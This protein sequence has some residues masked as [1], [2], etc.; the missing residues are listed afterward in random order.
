MRILLLEDDTTIGS[1]VQKGLSEEGH[2]VDLFTNGKDALVAAMTH[3]FDLFIFDRMVPE[4]DGLSLLKSLRASKNFTPVLFLTALGELDDRV[5]GFDAGGDDYL[6]KPFAFAELTAR[7]AALGRRGQHS[8]PNEKPSVL[9]GADIKL[10]LLARTCVRRGQ[11]IPLNA[12]EFRLLEYFMRRP[13]RVV[14]RTMLLEAVWEMS[15]DPT[16]SVVETHISR[17]RSKIEKPFGDD[18]IQTRRGAGYVFKA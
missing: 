17:L 3:E 8:Q 14:T 11:D 13:G 16:T 6:V 1:W 18:V 9:E 10:D 2:V 15:F 7:V 4:L 5:E 12:K